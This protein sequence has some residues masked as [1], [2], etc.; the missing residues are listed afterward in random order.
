MPPTIIWRVL[1]VLCIIGGVW[2]FCIEVNF[3][4]KWFSLFM[5]GVGAALLIIFFKNKD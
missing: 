2:N 5:A 3:W 4:V 1:G